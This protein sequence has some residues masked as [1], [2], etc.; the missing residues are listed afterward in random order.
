MHRLN[1]RTS[2]LSLAQAVLAVSVM[3]MPIQAY[4][5]TVSQ[6]VGYLNILVGLMLTAAFLFFGGGFITYIARLGLVGRDLGIQFMAW[7]VSIL[8]VLIIMLWGVRLIQTHTQVA[9]MIIALVVFVFMGKIIFSAIS[10]SQK[11][12][13]RPRR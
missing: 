13:E 12:E 5:V 8:F 4:A 10:A 6:L 11:E 1:H 3:F 2:L 9:I 7:G